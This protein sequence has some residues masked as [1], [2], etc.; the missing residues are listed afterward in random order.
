MASLTLII[1]LASVSLL[2][3]VFS[4]PLIFMLFVNKKIEKRYKCKLNIEMEKLRYM[5]FY[6]YN[7][8]S[9]PG[10]T[11]AVAVLFNSQKIIDKNPCLKSINYK[12]KTAPKMEKIICTGC[13]LFTAIS[14]IINLIVLGYIKIYGF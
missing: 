2:F 8:Y 9:N 7:K 10:K 11:I 12:L 6:A 1:G 4:F 3:I 14:V 5:P 13:Y